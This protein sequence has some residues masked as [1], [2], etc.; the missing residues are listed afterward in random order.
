MTR[1]GG[2][3]STTLSARETKSSSGWLTRCGFGSRL[4]AT[5]KNEV[6]ELAE[7]G[8]AERLVE[9]ARRR[10]PGKR[11]QRA[12]VVVVRVEQRRQQAETDALAASRLRD[13]QFDDLE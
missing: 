13:Q 7:L 11:E 9:L 12:A 10:I 3:D 2:I 4:A 5:Q 6:F 8:E 1:P